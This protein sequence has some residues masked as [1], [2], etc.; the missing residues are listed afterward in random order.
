[1]KQSIVGDVLGTNAGVLACV[2]NPLRSII[3]NGITIKTAGIGKVGNPHIAQHIV[4]VGKWERY[5]R[6][7]I[8]AN[9]KKYNCKIRVPDCEYG[10][11]LGIEATA[12]RTRW[13]KLNRYGN[14]LLLNHYVFKARPHYDSYDHE[15][16]NRFLWSYVGKKYDWKG[17]LEPIGFGNDSK[18]L[19]Y[20]SEIM[21]DAGMMFL[22]GYAPEWRDGCSPLDGQRH[23][24][25]IDSV[26]WRSYREWWG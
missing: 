10:T 14:S 13:T 20:C 21:R 25:A 7:I 8:L 22:A 2:I 18:S 12:P 16:I 23:F 6:E 17:L 4:M 3:G 15:A 24:E 11:L 1:M 26:Y 5:C 9:E 19:S